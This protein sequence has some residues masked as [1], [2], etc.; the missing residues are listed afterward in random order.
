M[1]E[2]MFRRLV[3]S[4]H[5]FYF[6]RVCHNEEDWWDIAKPSVLCGICG[7]EM[8]CTGITYHHPR[9]ENKGERIWTDQ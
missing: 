1:I 7:D 4:N 6:C 2:T 5:Y 8:I 3:E 9:K